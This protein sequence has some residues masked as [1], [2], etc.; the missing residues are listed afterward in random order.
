[1]RVSKL[2]DPQKIVLRYLNA[3]EK[4]SIK[5]LHYKVYVFDNGDPLRFQT[6]E[7][8]IALGL[9]AEHPYTMLYRLTEAGKIYLR[10]RESRVSVTS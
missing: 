1:M 3:D 2:T 8:L 6:V 7:K 9:I 5:L 10:T 4:R